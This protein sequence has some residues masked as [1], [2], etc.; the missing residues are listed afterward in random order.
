MH[1]YVR[2]RKKQYKLTFSMMNSVKYKYIN[3]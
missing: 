1:T 3:N 2:I